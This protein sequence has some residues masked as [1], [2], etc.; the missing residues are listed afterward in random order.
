MTI[1]RS[2][3]VLMPESLESPLL[4]LQHSANS[5]LLR[6]KKLSAG[7]RTEAIR[8]ESIHAV[9]DQMATAARANGEPTV[10][11]SEA[12]GLDLTG[13]SVLYQELLDPKVIP[14][15]I[16]EWITAGRVVVELRLPHHLGATV[17]GGESGRGPQP[18]AARWMSSGQG[19]AAAERERFEFLLSSALNSPQ[20]DKGTI[21][22]SDVSNKVLTECLRQK[23]EARDGTKRVDLRV[24]YRDGSE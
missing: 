24:T 15:E 23:V 10:F 5:A 14:E 1:E 19:T 4:R 3:Y 12:N 8:F 7:D 18:A 2:A 21:R 11:S 6:G 17:V 22:P 16:A 13:T 9:I 20:G